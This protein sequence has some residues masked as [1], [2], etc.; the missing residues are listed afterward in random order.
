MPFEFVVYGTPRSHSAA[1]TASRRLWQEHVRRA[2]MAALPAN[3]TPLEE[4]LVFRLLYVYVNERTADLDNIVKPIQ[5]ALKNLVYVDDLLVSDL[6]ASVRS[7]AN[8]LP[9][10]ESPLLEK[11]LKGDSDFVYILI[12]NA[13]VVEALR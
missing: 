8:V 10:V 7:K 6:V 9:P 11:G 1:S 5:D 12:D 2:A 4:P 13:G 3:A